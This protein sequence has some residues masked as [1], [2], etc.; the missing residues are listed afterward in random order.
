MRA[1]ELT[2]PAIQLGL[3]GGSKQEATGFGGHAVPEVLRELDALGERESADVEVGGAH[4]VSL[5]PPHGERNTLTVDIH[6]PPSAPLTP[7][8]QPARRAV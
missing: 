5:P 6:I 8:A 4:V 2:V 1:W 3:L 7:R